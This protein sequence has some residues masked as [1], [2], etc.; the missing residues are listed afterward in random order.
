MPNTMGSKM[1]G[2]AV[3]DFFLSKNALKIAFLSDT[4]HDHLTLKKH[5]SLKIFDFLRGVSENLGHK[6]SDEP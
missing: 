4:N 1:D 6:L 3:R 2:L 5:N